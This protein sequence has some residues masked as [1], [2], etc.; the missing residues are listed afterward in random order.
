MQRKFV[1]KLA[2]R[3]VCGTSSYGALVLNHTRQGAHVEDI[4]RITQTEPSK[5]GMSHMFTNTK[6]LDTNRQTARVLRTLA[7]NHIFSEILPDVFANNRI[8]SCL[9]T[10]KSVQDILARYGPLCS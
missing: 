4:A 2:L 3:F 6:S 7:T 9:D 5:L 10:G 1:E 8:S